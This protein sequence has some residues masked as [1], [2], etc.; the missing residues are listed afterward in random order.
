MNINKILRRVLLEDEQV[1]GLNYQDQYDILEKGRKNC[2]TFARE[3]GDRP[4]KRLE[5]SSVSLFPAL[6]SAEEVAY[7]STPQDKNGAIKMFFAIDDPNSTSGKK[8]FVTYYVKGGSSPRKYTQGWGIDCEYMQTTEELGKDNMSDEQRKTLQ[9]FLDSNKGNYYSFVDKANQGEFIK[10]PYTELTW[11]STGRKVLPDY[12]G[13]GFVFKRANLENVNQDKMEQTSVALDAQGF[14]REEPLD[15]QSPEA[16]AGFFLKDIAKDLPALASVAKLSPNTKVWPKPG[17]LIVPSRG[18]CKDA[19]KR[20]SKCSKSTSIT[21]DCTRDLWK[22]KMLA[23]QCG[24]KN[25]SGGAIGIGD[26]FDALLVD[27]GRFGLANLKTARQQGFEEP[28]KPQGPDLSIKENLSMIVSNV[29]NEEYKR[30]NY[31][32]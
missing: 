30:R 6:G 8:S 22:N 26:E 14:T 5:K 25:F 3:I 31:R 27:T 16:N 28:E 12:K 23:L 15:A 2:P 10:V 29:L 11:P 1:R 4:V 17:T 21:A 9:S 18:T 32:K 19:I 20:L 24:D 7:I 13:P